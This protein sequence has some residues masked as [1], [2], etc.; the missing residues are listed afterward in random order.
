ME[1]GKPR[2]G[3]GAPRGASQ[4]GA[5]PGRRA[6][7]RSGR[8]LQPPAAAPGSAR[9][10]PPPPAAATAASA[11]A[12]PRPAPRGPAAVTPSRPAATH[13]LRFVEHEPSD[14]RGLSPPGP[15]A[16][17]AAAPVPV[18]A[19]VG[20]QDP[21]SRPRWGRGRQGLAAAGRGCSGG[22]GQSESP[23]PQRKWGAGG[24][25]GGRVW[26]A[27]FLLPKTAGQV[28]GVG[29]RAPVVF[30]RAGEFLGLTKGLLTLLSALLEETLQ[31]WL[32][33]PVLLD[34]L[35]SFV[36]RVETTYNCLIKKP[37]AYLYLRCLYLRGP[38]RRL[39]APRAQIACGLRHRMSS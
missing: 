4:A 24:P 15:G 10:R 27:R 13:A 7:R 19:G 32:C 31:V 2:C 21:A 8:L 18:A 1:G 5:E 30:R 33:F 20:A 12:P 37:G 36:L 29:V 16:R 34:T 6:A 25:G 38:L 35:G 23:G 28:G 9:R 3:A 39:E 22:M 14:R 17:P 26:V 11:P